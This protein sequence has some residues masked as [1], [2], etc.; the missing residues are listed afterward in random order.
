[1]RLFSPVITSKSY[2]ARG[3]VQKIKKFQNKNFWCPSTP[4]RI[5][6]K[7]STII[8][9]KSVFLGQSSYHDNT[10]VTDM[11]ISKRGN[12]AN[13]KIAIFGF[14][15]IADSFL[16]KMLWNFLSVT[17]VLH[18]FTWKTCDYNILMFGRKYAKFVTF[19]CQSW[20]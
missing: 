17:I 10:T 8:G 4:V 20:L 3:G 14:F 1:M 18:I 12:S 16:V 19:W 5:Y 13:D 15:G 2:N 6:K 11:F 9:E 7:L